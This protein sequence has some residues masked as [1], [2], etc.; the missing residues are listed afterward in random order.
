MIREANENDA[1]ALEILFQLTRQKT[2]TYASP[3]A[4]KIGDYKKSV[5][6]EEVWVAEAD[7]KIIGFV[8]L[9]LPDNF[10][11]NLFIHPDWQGRGIGSLLLKKAEERLSFPI[12]LKVT[13]TNSKACVFYEKHGWNKVAIGNNGIEEYFLYRKD[14]F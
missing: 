14:K 7:G 2:F 3:D 8:S 11:H 10:I 6:G 4:F 12:E 5:E 13:T 9:W 1:E